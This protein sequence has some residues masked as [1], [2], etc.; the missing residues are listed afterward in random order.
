[1]TPGER[2]DAM[3]AR[4]KRPSAR[5]RRWLWKWAWC[6]WAHRRHKCWPRDPGRW[7]CMKCHPCG[8]G[9]DMLVAAFAEEAKE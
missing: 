9:I 7:H 4:R 2:F 1:M 6:S 5:L 3:L 8:E